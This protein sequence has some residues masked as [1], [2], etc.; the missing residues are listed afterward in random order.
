M[1]GA[2]E[3]YGCWGI[4]GS[5]GCPARS[6]KTENDPVPHECT[7]PL[8]RWNLGREHA[9]WAETIGLNMMLVPCVSCP[10]KENKPDQPALLS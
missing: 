5:G 8:V 10:V 4:E 3:T 1:D 9:R 7:L 6:S 2:S